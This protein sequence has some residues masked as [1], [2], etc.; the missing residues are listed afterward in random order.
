VN[1]PALIT[2]EILEKE[3]DQRAYAG[4]P[5]AVA[6]LLEGQFRSDYEN[7]VPP[8]IS[9]NK[10]IGFVP[11]SKPNRM[12]VVSDGDVIKNQLHYSKGYPLP[13]GYDQYTG[14]TFGN[15]DFIL[16]SL[17][18][19]V[20]ESGLISIRSRQLKL[21]MLDMTRV[22]NNKISWQAFNIIFPVLLVLI[23]GFVRNYM[24]KRKYASG[25]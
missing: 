19:L 6:V 10:D 24:R 13:L 11:L 21:R 22:T 18:Y 20:D 8:E 5:Q 12:I 7:R 17:D 1:T 23:F 15:K 2:L 3:P 16:N 14:E 9:T 4:P 25:K